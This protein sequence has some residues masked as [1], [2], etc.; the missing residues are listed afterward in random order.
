MANQLEK[1]YS[2]FSGTDTRSNKLL[3]DPK[4]FRKG[5]KNFRYNF[6][7]EIQ[8]RQG[9]QHKDSGAPTFVDIFEYKYKD[10]NTGESKT[11]VLGVATDG[12]LYREKNSVIFFS[13]VSYVSFYYD[14]NDNDFKLDLGGTIFP[15]TQTTT[16]SSLQSAV[17]AA[18]GVGKFTYSGTSTDLAY[19]MDFAINKPVSFKSYIYKWEKVPFPSSILI[20]F[21]TTFLYN[22]SSE[23]QGISSVNLNN[24]IYITDGG[25]PMKYDGKSIC[26]AGL[27]KSFSFQVQP[28]ANAPG[29]GDGGFIVE[30]STSPSGVT[31]LA[32]G[33][34]K[35]L[36]RFGFKDFNGFINYGLIDNE[37][38][39]YSVT[40][41]GGNANSKITMPYFK[42]GSDF[43]VFSCELS[44]NQNWGSGTGPFTINVASGHNI[45]EGMNLMIPA[46]LSGGI[47]TVNSNLS[48]VRYFVA[49]VS[50]VTTTS[51]TINNGPGGRPGDGLFS[52]TLSGTTINAY[53][54]PQDFENTSI[55]S[56]TSG[57][58]VPYG[59]FV[60]VYRSKVN[61]FDNYYLVGSF[62][63]PRVLSEEYFWYDSTPD[64]DLISL[65]NE[66]AQ[67]EELPR[68]C[69]YLSQWQNQLVQGGRPINNALADQDYPSWYNPINAYSA[70]NQVTAF[71]QNK[72]TEA[73]L[74]D[75]QSIYWADALTPEGFPQDAR[76]SMTVDTNFADKITGIAPNKEAFF[77]FKTRSTAIMTGTAA[78]VGDQFLEILETDAGCSSHRSI[79]NVR[80]S[81]IW[82]DGI[83][84]FYACVA[85]RLPENIGWPIQDYQKINALGLDYSKAVSANFR[86]ESLYVCSVGGTTFVFDYAD[87]GPGKRA[88]WYIWDG[89][90]IK[91]LLATSNNELLFNDSSRTWKMKLTNSIYDYTDHTSAINLVINTAWLNQGFP[92]IDKHYIGFWIN[93]IQGDFTLT[94]NQYGN[95]LDDVIGTQDNLQ[96]I[97]ESSSKKFV[98][99]QVKAAMPK[100]SSISFGMENSEKNKW[101]RIQGYEIQYSPDFSIGEPKR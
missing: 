92:T 43:G 14:E 79:Q 2:S 46:L 49:Y 10:I 23:Y 41:S 93:S 51:I 18:L 34:Y 32:N 53:W 3:Q 70:T 65:Y 72:Y 11:E 8:N 33:T 58:S 48:Y 29:R 1:F 73:L 66:Q 86:K 64:S 55:T 44:S 62:P 21:R 56:G 35:Y 83:N 50:S 17:T 5:S 75:Y 95:F 82:L 26:R 90:N 19:L 16:L 7:D 40:L 54:A 87:N 20:P 25:F 68:A 31:S 96:F 71:F 100:L 13:G 15:V 88:C 39:Q 84:G 47:P 9:F 59:A 28:I 69:K 99:A 85:G 30:S 57:N 94:V 61:V 4:S 67:G 78:L 97:A 52:Y 12:F 45:V 89:L 60:E 27:P 42:S 91:S 24:V 63:M 36:F 101:V 6:Q 38:G 37:Q 76:Y 80:G 81:L 77:I 22:T 98:K 74:C